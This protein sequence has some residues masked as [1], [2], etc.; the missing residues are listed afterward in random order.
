MI[1][2]NPHVSNDKNIVTGINDIVK[3]CSIKITAITSSFK[4]VC[5]N[6]PPLPTDVFHDVNTPISCIN[7]MDIDDTEDKVH[8]VWKIL[9]G[10][11]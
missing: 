2:Y 11:L 5:I 3:P 4:D 6:K 10:V 1:K 7:T 9:P 8:M